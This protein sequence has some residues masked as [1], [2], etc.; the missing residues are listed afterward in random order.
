MEK[1]FTKIAWRL[2]PFMGLLYVVNFLDR[3]NVGFAALTM[4][5][6]LGLGA[7]AFGVG[8][9]IFFLGYFFFEV[10]SN[11]ILERVG[12]RLWIFRI[13]F[14][15]GLVS[16]AMAFAQG[17]WSFYGLRFLLGVTEAGFFPGMMLYLTY[18]FPQSERAKFNSLFFAAIPLSSALG[19]PLS[20]FILG[21]DGAMGLHGW[22]WL[23][24]LEGLPSCVL[25]FAVLAFMPNGPAS[26]RF[27]DNSEKHFVLQ[28]LA[29]EAPPRKG[30]R[31]GLG[32]WRVWVLAVT[33]IG[34][35]LPLY[36]LNLWLPQIVKAMGFTNL[37][38]GFVVAFPYAAS[39]IGMIL[40]A[41]SSDLS[42]ERVWHVA[43][44]VLFA[45]ASL[46]AAA[47]LGAH[48]AAVIALTAASI[49]IY[50]ALVTYWT[51]P[52]S[53]LG[54]TAAAGGIAFINSVG[55]LGGFFGPA[56][57]GWLKQSTGGYEAGMF[58][59]AA[60]LVAPA[61]VVVLLA[62]TRTLALAPAAR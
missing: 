57:M 55:N 48:V 47:L 17:T 8:A 20:G 37:E 3:V 38:T 11:V 53:F 15:W 34:I 62:R 41:R 42:R 24:L 32:D 56:L 19:S 23:F 9:G 10:P 29:E 43:I 35:I 45:S 6:D 44:P 16:M 22:Q 54:G 39:T 25:A 61:I 51:L 50:A 30:L 26:A 46:A 58:V 21:F 31:S 27:L 36:G 33:D 13:M 7:E 59:L 5:R 1:I 14:S 4:N 12:A 52:P 18:W 40:W 28:R 60:F 2:I 49:G